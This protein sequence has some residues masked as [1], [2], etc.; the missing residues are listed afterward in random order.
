VCHEIY[1]W[2]QVSEEL[3]LSFG[4]IVLAVLHVIL[5]KPRPQPVIFCLVLSTVIRSPRMLALMSEEMS[6]QV[7]PT[8]SHRLVNCPIYSSIIYFQLFDFGFVKELTKSLYD[9][10]SGQYKL[11]PHTGSMPYMSP[12]VL[13]GKPYGKPS[14][15]FSF[16]V[17]LW[18]MLH[19]KY[20]VSIKD[21]S[22]TFL[23]SSRA[24]L[25]RYF[26]SSS[27]TLTEETTSMLLS[28]EIID[29]RLIVLCQL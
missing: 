21:S 18:E 16:G 2:T 28:D 11:T 10:D 5:F 4:G 17:M 29:L 27:I 6:R 20:A 1:C 9:K 26:L 23:Q 25:H 15:V 13:T 24:Q 7:A 19:F 3:W 8:L 22:V 14:D 12:E